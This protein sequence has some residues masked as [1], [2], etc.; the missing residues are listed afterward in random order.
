[1]YVFWL[2]VLR[3]RSTDTKK[4]RKKEGTSVDALIL[5]RS[6]NKII[7]GDREREVPG[8]ERKGGGER[9]EGSGIGG[10]RREAQRAGE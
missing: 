2:S 1:V 6:G 10:D 9:G 8:W 5:L 4:L 3:V 7:M